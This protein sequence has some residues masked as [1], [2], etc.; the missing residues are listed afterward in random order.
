GLPGTSNLFTV[1]GQNENDPFLN[2]NNSGA[3][4]LLLG[5]NDVQEA[6]VVNNGYAGQ[7]GQLAGANVNYVTKSG[8]NNWHGNANY[9]WNGR[10]MNANNYFNKQSGIDRPFVNANQW[11]A[12]LGGPIIKNKTFFFVNTEGLRVVLPTNTP[13][14]IPSPQF[15]AA[16]L[17][18]LAA[19]NPASIPFY[20]RMF[21]LYNGANGA[22]RAQNILPAGSDPVTGAATG[23]GCTDLAATAYTLLPAGSPCALQFRST[24]NNFTH[25]WL[26]TGRVDQNIGSNDRAFVHF[27]TDHGFQATYTDP[28]NPAFNAGS[29]QPQYEGQLNETHTFGATSV[30]QFILSGSW[31][32]AIFNVANPAA[33]RALMP[34][35]LGF[36]GNAFYGL[37]RL[38]ND[39]PQGRNVTQYQIV[40]D[41]SKLHGSH[42]LKF[43]VNFRRNDITDYSPGFFTTGY[44][45]GEDLT[46]YINGLGSSYTQNFPVRLTQPVAVYGLGFYGQDDWAIHNNLHVTLSLRADHN[47]NPVC[48]T[49]CFARFGGGFF[50]TPH[51][52]A[53]PYNQT[54]ITG[55]HQALIDYDT[56]NWQ[57]RF[58]FAWSPFGTG[59]DTVFRG[60]FGLFTD[61]FPATVVDSFMNNPPVNN[62]FTVGPGFLSPD[63]AG[64][65]QSTAA[66][67]NA[68]FVTGFSSGGTLAS[69]AA[70]NPFF[71][72]PNFTNSSR[73]IHSPRYQEWNLEFQQG[74]GQKM[75]F[76]IN[77]VGNHGIFE[78][79]QNAGVNAFCDPVVCAGLLTTFTGVPSTGFQGLPTAP[80]DPRFGIVTE[81][82]SDAVSNYNGVTVSFARR[83]SRI[84]VQANYTWSHALDEISN[85]GFLPFNANTNFSILQ[86]QDPFHLRRYN[87]GNADYDT[88]HYFSMNYVWNTASL[89]GWRGALANWLVSGT[90]YTRTGYPYTAVDGNATA[91]LNAVG[92]FGV[93]P[94]AGNPIF[95]NY[96][97]GAPV[98]CDRRALVTPCPNPA[99]FTPAANGFGQQR[100][101]QLY[102]PS[103]FDTD[104][105]VQKNFKLPI[106][107]A[108]TFGIGLQFFNLLNHPN[109]DQPVGD[110]SDPQ[111]GL[112]R[113]TVSVPTS[114]VGSFLGG[115][116]SPRLIQLKASVTF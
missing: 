67:A 69:I 38:L 45:S 54:I 42:S 75:S 68:S 101:N 55:R 112:I 95:A 91:V 106:S 21:A 52:P 48:Q 34:F 18:N 20:Q 103:F 36:S 61:V 31:Y 105:T 11:G 29:D 90:L 77:Y 44:S 114:I 28:I 100:R 40:D 56:I 59:R 49:N 116:A 24:V 27:R 30:N 2:L 70:T 110:I 113:N 88:R 111:F 12:S 62:P 17:A 10:V 74:I 43:G 94:G 63:V 4:N 80:I 3:T 57:P 72:P 8:T 35:R 46:S 51:N 81:I 1:N 7:Y 6:T 5:Q 53:T 85:A 84:Q 37:G 13:V 76:S 107:E 99:A 32:S 47:S 65:Q 9:F 15:Q 33:A 60:G 83:L 93:V 98:G 104:L 108:S 92:N 79:N 64:N 71:V 86:P 82:Q 25:E 14:N 102:G 115:D 87:Y 19:V 66:G 16:T 50:D 96:I 73:R 23:N 26:L 97:G 22:T 41:F 78:A 89:G 39:W 58:G 109:F